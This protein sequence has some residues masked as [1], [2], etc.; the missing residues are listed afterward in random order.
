MPLDLR[1]ILVDVI[2]VMVGSVRSLGW[3]RRKFT[4][5][6]SEFALARETAVSDAR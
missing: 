4:I 5:T 2:G 1:H 3:L 6:L